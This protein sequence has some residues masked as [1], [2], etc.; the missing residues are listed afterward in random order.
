MRRSRW[1]WGPSFDAGVCL[2]ATRE[3]KAIHPLA[4]PFGIHLTLGTFL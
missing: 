2:E 1:Q 4:S 3:K